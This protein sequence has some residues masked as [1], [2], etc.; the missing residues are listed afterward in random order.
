M[1]QSNND[2]ELAKHR[3]RTLM[4][5]LSQSLPGPSPPLRSKASA[6]G[7]SEARP[8][9][10]IDAVADHSSGDEDFFE[11]PSRD[12]DSLPIPELTIP[13]R[14]ISESSL[15]SPPPEL[16]PSSSDEEKKDTEWDFILPVLTTPSTLTPW[17]GGSQQEFNLPDIIG[18]VQHG[19]SLQMM[20][21]YLEHYE[22]A[23]V[24]RN[25]NGTV[26]G[27]PAMFYVTATNDESIIRAWIAYGGDV[28]ATHEASETPLLA[29]AIMH[30][31]TIQTDTTLIVATLLS[32][33]ASPQVIPTAFYTPYCQDLPDN[34]P[35]D[36]MLDDMNDETRHW[37]TN[38]A[39]AKLARTTNL[40]QRYYL[41]RAAKT[42][43]PSIRHRQIALRRNA[44]AL[45]GIPYFLIGQTIAANRLLQ[46]LLSHIMVA[47]KRPL[48]L[49]FAGPS[50]HG[51]TELAR[52][53]GH[54]LSL[55]LEV[56][57]CTI[58][59]RELEL[60]GPRAPYVGADRGSPLNNFLARN[61]GERSIVFLDEFEKTTSDIHQ[62]LLLPFDHGMMDDF[63]FPDSDR[64][65]YIQ[66][67]T[68]IDVI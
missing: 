49:A 56:V 11:T 5:Y 61:A 33:G 39:R 60:F 66:G 59:N 8:G 13:T 53:L 18:A 50:G 34:G 67:N 28:T 12:G 31:E 20:Q 2:P 1:Q 58:V 57:D 16:D 43:K 21:S 37:L 15:R 30:S 63:S 64:L 27:F 25:I 14:S 65:T 45:L 24:K 26:E 22:K 42:K 47:S 3:H 19:A 44:E 40:T 41:D 51:K 62:A 38:A 4:K 68:R 23:T 9:D 10:E 7:I 17:A 52:R 46:K 29:F 48:V 6:F 54:L 32:L 55:E 35:D 36:K